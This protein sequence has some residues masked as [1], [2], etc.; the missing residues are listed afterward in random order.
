MVVQKFQK[1][2]LNLIVLDIQTQLPHNCKILFFKERRLNETFP[3]FLSAKRRKKFPLHWTLESE[4]SRRW[5][6]S[7]QS[8][9]IKFTFP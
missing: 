7:D 4:G 6:V 2:F 1:K 3:I 9:V 5:Y 8:L